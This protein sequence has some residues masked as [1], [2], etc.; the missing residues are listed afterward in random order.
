VLVN[1]TIS[2]S[3]GALSVILITSLNLGPLVVPS[4]TQFLF[5]FLFFAGQI[6]PRASHMLSMCSSTEPH[7]QPNTSPSLLRVQLNIFRKVLMGG[8]V[9]SH[10]TCWLCCHGVGS[11]R[12]GESWKELKRSGVKEMVC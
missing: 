2:E 1:K 5:L 4:T 3:P 12:G 10:G 9:F 11:L 7:L 8:C 6:T